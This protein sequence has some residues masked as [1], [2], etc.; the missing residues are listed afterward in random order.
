MINLKSITCKRE[1]LMLSKEEFIELIPSSPSLTKLLFISY[2][3]G[4]LV[5]IFICIQDYLETNL[6]SI[7]DLEVLRELTQKESL[8]S[9]NLFN[10]F[11]HE[12]S[13][14]L[15]MGIMAFFI[16]KKFKQSML[17]DWIVEES[18]YMLRFIESKDYLNISN[19]DKE[20]INYSYT[21]DPV[22]KELPYIAGFFNCKSMSL[23]DHQRIVMYT[24]GIMK[25]IDCPNDMMK[26]IAS[27]LNSQ[28]FVFIVDQFINANNTMGTRIFYP[29]AFRQNWVSKVSFV[30]NRIRDHIKNNMA[31]SN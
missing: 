13:R 9:T 29:N 26:K 7:D 14:E 12:Y 22:E 3:P 20:L 6:N 28:D 8:H 16:P 5:D 15:N 24:Q 21:L 30:W 18:T 10:K 23:G 31:H 25:G 27:P 19:F 11:W 1:N 17:K 4:S 2:V